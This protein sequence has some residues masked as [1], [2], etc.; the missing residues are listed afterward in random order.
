[1]KKISIA[2]VTIL[3]AAVLGTT[4]SLALAATYSPDGPYIGVYAQPIDED[5]QEAFN[6]SRDKGIVLV[7]VMEQ[8]PA[9]KAGLQREDIIISFNGKK[10]DGTTPLADLVAETKVGDKVAVVYDRAGEQNTAIIEIGTRP[11]Q[12][13]QQA[14]LDRNA[15]RTLSRSYIHSGETSGYIGVAIQDLNDQLG[16][17]FGVKDGEGV[18]VTEVFEDS[19]ASEAGIKAGDVITGID[20][21]SV[22]ESADLQDIIAEKKEGDK[23]AVHFLRRGSKMDLSVEVKEDV[24]GMN[25]FSFPQNSFQPMQRDKSFLHRFFGDDNGS[26]M[27]D[28]T[29]NEIQKLKEELKAMREDMMEMQKNMKK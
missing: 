20:D 23:V 28:D 19:P 8:S 17:Y 18:L 14:W 4:F 27:Q 10:V 9:D 29:R 12:D 26:R 1:M 22:A 15:P 11:K 7:D 25:S 6:L 16:D 24:L 2:I 13:K 3:L 5:L 21:Q